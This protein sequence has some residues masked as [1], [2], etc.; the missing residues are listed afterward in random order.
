MG[1]LHR[2]YGDKLNPAGGKVVVVP[3][4]VAENTAKIVPL[5]VFPRAMYLKSAYIIN[6]ATIAAHDTDYRTFTLQDRGSNGAGT[7]AVSTARNT[8]IT[9][10]GGALTAF[11]DA[12]LTAT[13][14]YKLV[15][16]N[17]LAINCEDAGTA[18]AVD[19]IVVLV[20]K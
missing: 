20:F 11:V 15:G 4:A 14:G 1:I 7:T 3:V 19:A 10:G 9:A 5:F 2:G 6:Q 12:D 17:V 13:D 8:K 18:P 16:G